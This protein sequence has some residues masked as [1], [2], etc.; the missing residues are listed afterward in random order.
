MTLPE[1]IIGLQAYKEVE[2]RM[3]KLWHDVDKAI[4]FPRMDT[5]ASSLPS[6]R[7][8]EVCPRDDVAAQLLTS[9]ERC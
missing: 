3:S 7:E 4:V 6:I 8:T 1:A 2:D 5:Q 9:V